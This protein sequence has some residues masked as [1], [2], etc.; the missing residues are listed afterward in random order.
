GRRVTDDDPWGFARSLE[1]ATTSPPPRHN[2][3]RIPRI[4]SE[5]PAFDFHY[6]HVSAGRAAVMAAGSQDARAGIAGETEQ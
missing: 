2:F 6:P 5:H 1:W 4:R 3:V